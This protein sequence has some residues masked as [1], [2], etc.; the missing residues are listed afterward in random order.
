MPRLLVVSDVHSNQ[1]ALE[2]VLADAEKEGP[3]DQ[4]LCAGDIVGY[5]PNPNEVVARIRNDFGHTVLG[6]HDRA[7]RNPME[8]GNFNPHAKA[9]ALH[10]HN[11]LT[12]DNRAFLESLSNEP[13]LDPSNQYALVHGNFAGTAQGPLGFYRFED[14]YTLDRESVAMAL[15]HLRFGSPLLIDDAPLGIVG[16]THSPLFAQA[17]VDYTARGFD[18]VSFAGLHGFEYELCPQQEKFVLDLTA[19]P[20]SVP[21][22]CVP[23]ILFNPGSV[24]Q[25]RDHDP[26]AAYGVIEMEGSK[27][28]FHFKRVS[29][30]VAETQRRMRDAQGQ[31]FSD[32]LIR[33]LESGR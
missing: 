29:Y 20:A 18:W 6:N 25:P 32:W 8:M 1:V 31:H 10:N 24:G 12:P 7:V 3:Y 19:K 33:R 28:T 9:A 23:K 4:K 11:I 2:A 13:Y 14:L 17:W 30:D 26:R 22:G 5:G 21:D 27:L 16:H 15:K